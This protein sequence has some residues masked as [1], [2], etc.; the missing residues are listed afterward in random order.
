[1]WLGDGEFNPYGYQKPN[2]AYLK[3]GYE[4]IVPPYIYQVQDHGPPNGSEQYWVVAVDKNGKENGPIA[5]K[6]AGNIMAMIWLK[7]KDSTEL[8]S[9]NAYPG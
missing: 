7:S 6:T 2:L 1:M 4:A 8:N 9:Y 5:M 3:G